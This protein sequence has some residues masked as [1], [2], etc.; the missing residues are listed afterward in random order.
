MATPSLP[1]ART[2]RELGGGVVGGIAGFIV[3]GQTGR[4]LGDAVRGGPYRPKHD[5]EIG[6]LYST[7]GWIVGHSAGS[8]VGVYYSGRMDN[9][10]DSFGQTLIGATAGELVGAAVYFV[11]RGYEGFSLPAAAVMVVAAPIGAV[12]GF[13]HSRRAEARSGA[14]AGLRSAQY[15]L[16]ALRLAF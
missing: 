2:A 4:L 13:N 8:A 1:D 10:A 16:V 5:D 12:I 15:R 3:G 11:V 14:N 6:D 9:V 7:V